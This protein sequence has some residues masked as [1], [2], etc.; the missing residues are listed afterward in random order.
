MVHRNDEHQAHR[1]GIGSPLLERGLAYL[2]LDRVPGLEV[3]RQVAL[4]AERRRF[5]L[6]GK[7]FGAVSKTF[8]LAAASAR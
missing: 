4:A 8:P 1:P 5:A 3:V 2:L 6:S 7:G